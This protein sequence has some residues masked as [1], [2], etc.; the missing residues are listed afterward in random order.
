MGM[1]GPLTEADTRMLEFAVVYRG[2]PDD[3][4]AMIRQQ[5]AA[6]HEEILPGLTGGIVT[7]LPEG[8]DDL[9]AYV[10]ELATAGGF[11]ATD[12]DARSFTVP[13][14]WTDPTRPEP[15]TQFNIGFAGTSDRLINEPFGISIRISG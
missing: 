11:G 12:D 2:L 8:R 6:R 5:V 15:N 13:N 9:D 4:K 14:Y 10:E 3:W 1:A 7:A